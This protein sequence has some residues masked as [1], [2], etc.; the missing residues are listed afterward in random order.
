MFCRAVQNA[1]VYS[2]GLY[3]LVPRPPCPAFVA[4]SMKSRERPGRIYHVVLWLTSC[5]A[6]HAVSISVCHSLRHSQQKQ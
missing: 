5:I 3:S 6:S 4:C 2:V 1:L